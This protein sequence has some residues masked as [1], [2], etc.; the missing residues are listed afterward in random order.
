M[1]FWRAL[2]WNSVDFCPNL[3]WSLSK[4]ASLSLFLGLHLDSLW[5]LTS[6]FLDLMTVAFWIYALI[7]LE[8]SK[9]EYEINFW[10]LVFMKNTFILLAHFIFIIHLGIEFQSEYHFHSEFEGFVSLLFYLQCFNWKVQ[11]HSDLE[12]F[13]F[14]PRKLLFLL[15]GFKKLN[16]TAFEKVSWCGFF[17]FIVLG[18]WWFLSVCTVHSWFSILRTFFCVVSW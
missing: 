11:Y 2:F 16:H 4:P 3:D 7:L 17:W 8:S 18:T 13:C 12:S 5:C 10:N 6:C 1:F 9:R 15:P 14:P